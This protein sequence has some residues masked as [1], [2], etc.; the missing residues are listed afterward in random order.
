MKWKEHYFEK[1]IYTLLSGKC[2]LLLKQI[3][4]TNKYTMLVPVKSDT[5]IKDEN[6]IN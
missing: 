2:F 6:L 4:S 3:I 1:Y 5:K